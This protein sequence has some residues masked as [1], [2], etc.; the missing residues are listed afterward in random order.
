MRPSRSARWRCWSASS[1]LMPTG[2]S[3][4]LIATWRPSSSSRASQTVPMPPPPSCDCRRY[5]PATRRPGVVT[6]RVMDGCGSGGSDRGG[7]PEPARVLLLGAGRQG[8]VELAELGVHV[9]G[10]VVEDLA[11]GR[12]L[13]VAAGQQQLPGLRLPVALAPLGQEL[14]QVGVLGCRLLGGRGAGRQVLGVSTLEYADDRL[15]H[16]G[17]HLVRL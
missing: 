17:A 4:C 13:V 9:G 10:Q 15:D 14:R 11:P 2:V 7:D 6:G 12:R 16:F 8:V 1:A 3:T 5:L